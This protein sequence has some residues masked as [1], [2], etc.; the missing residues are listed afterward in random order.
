[1]GSGR[2]INQDQIDRLFTA[3]LEAAIGRVEK[4]GYFHPLVFELR[5][6]GTIQ[7]VA[8][9]ETGVTDTAR[10]PADRMGQ[11]LKSRAQDGRIEASAIVHM[12]QQERALEVRLRA[13]SYSADIGVPYKLETSGLVKRQRRVVLGTFSAEL[14]ENDVFGGDA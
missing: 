10:G 14:A 11:L 6:G 3:A 4:D 12:R 1:M 9:L 8:V 7:A 5:P 2:A 13:P